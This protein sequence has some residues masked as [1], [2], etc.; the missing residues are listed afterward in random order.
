MPKERK[1]P[2]FFSRKKSYRFDRFSVVSIQHFICFIQNIQHIDREREN[3]K[4]SDSMSV[5][6]RNLGYENM[7]S[8]A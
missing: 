3:E 4:M 8:F 2:N 7:L 5:I 6:R 1:K